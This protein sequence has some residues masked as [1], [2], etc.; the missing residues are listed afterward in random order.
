MKT[1]HTLALA[2]AA[3]TLLAAAAAQAGTLENLERERAIVIETMFNPTLN[4]EERQQKLATAQHRL[5]DLERMVLRD[6]SLKG[7]TDPIV[8]KAFENYDLTFMVHAAVE[9]NETLTDH[10]LDQV[11]LSTH[12]LMNARVGRR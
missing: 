7:R 3:A 1:T 8:I 4:A 5:V 12:N 6:E 10:W 9:K 2:A 11:G